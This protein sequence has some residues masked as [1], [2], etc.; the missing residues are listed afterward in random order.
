VE[1]TRVLAR[2]S[3]AE[4][5]THA[6]QL[7]N[8]RGTSREV[9]PLERA[10]AFENGSA[11]LPEGTA[12]LRAETLSP[13]QCVKTTR[14]AHKVMVR[15][16]CSHAHRWERADRLRSTP[17]RRG[18][19]VSLPIETQLVLERLEGG[20]R[21]GGSVLLRSPIGGSPDAG[22]VA[23][24]DHLVEFACNGTYKGTA[25]MRMILIAT[26]GSAESREDA[27]AEAS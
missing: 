4:P 16:S 14:P 9:E 15:R 18:R 8:K 10:A 21:P 17:E 24:P 2:R 22:S 25:T 1:R 11:G 13:S 6:K 3:S 19:E 23:A 27:P 12:L 26:D 7:R 20:R 5:L